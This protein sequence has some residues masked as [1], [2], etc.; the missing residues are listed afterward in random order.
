MTPRLT[1]LKTIPT[2]NPTN[3]ADAYLRAA[4]KRLPDINPPTKA[5]IKGPR[6]IPSGPN[7]NPAT[8]PTLE[9]HTT[10]LLPPNFLVLQTGKKLSRIATTSVN[11]PTT[12]ITVQ[13]SLGF[14]DGINFKINNPSQDNGGPGRTGRKDPTIPTMSNIAA[15]AIKI[16]SNICWIDLCCMINDE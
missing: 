3:D 13:E 16:G 9:P 5:P 4:R 7:Q 2:T 8:S 12:I 15:K 10:Y 6:I 14:T 11:S 1:N